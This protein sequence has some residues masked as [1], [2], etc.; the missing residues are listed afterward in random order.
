MEHTL[1][2]IAGSEA[3]ERLLFLFE[4]TNSEY[5][6]IGMGKT[7]DGEE[8]NAYVFSEGVYKRVKKYLENEEGR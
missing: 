1:H 3:E 8:A 5:Y 2:V 6:K 7:T 4:E